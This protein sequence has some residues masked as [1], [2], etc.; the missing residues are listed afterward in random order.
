[1]PMRGSVA[2]LYFDNIRLV[3]QIALAAAFELCVGM[4]WRRRKK[5]A[6]NDSGFPANT[7]SSAALDAI[8]HPLQRLFRLI[9]K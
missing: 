3:F 2:D 9:P 5:A 7:N 1:M 8:C 4:T 6:I